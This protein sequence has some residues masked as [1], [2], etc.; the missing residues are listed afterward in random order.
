MI[1]VAGKRTSLQELTAQL[2]AVR[3]VEDGVVFMPEGA[4]RPAAAVV[5]P[6]MTS[7]AVLAELRA[8]LDGVLVP[9]PLL[10]VDRLP[11]NELGKLPR[12]ALVHLLE[13]A[14]P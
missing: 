7:A 12:E 10:L 5:A 6:G 13:S 4:E 2:L 8:H 11:R 14:R 1:K 9:R 3:G